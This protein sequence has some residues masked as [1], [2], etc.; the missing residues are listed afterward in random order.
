MVVKSG[1]NGIFTK[2]LK[3]GVS[4]DKDVTVTETNT[5]KNEDWTL[6]V[7]SSG[8]Q[9]IY[10]VYSPSTGTPPIDLGA[11]QNS[12]TT[13]NSALVDIAW[14]KAIPFN[15]LITDP[16]KKEQIKQATLRNIEKRKQDVLPIAPVFRSVNR[17]DH[18][19]SQAYSPT[20]VGD[21]NWK[22]EG[23]AFVIYNVQVLGTVPFYDYWN[24]EDH[25]YETGYHPGGI[26]GYKYYGQVLGYV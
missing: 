25:Y 23:A 1:F 17:I 2:I 7:E 5:K 24:G 22:Y 16:I 15:E 10:S 19:Y 9:A 26:E 21:H 18:Y 8:G 11:W 6:F 4:A 12:I 3:F 20:Y 14:D 13:R